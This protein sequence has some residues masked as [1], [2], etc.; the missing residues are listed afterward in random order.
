MP[1]RVS[2][3]AAA[4]ASTGLT[5]LTL[6]QASVMIR[7]GKVTPSELTEAC[8]ARIEIYNPKLDAF[9][10]VLRTQAME[11]ARILDQEQKSGKLRGPL[12]GIPVAV[13]DNMQT[14]GVRT[15]FGS[16]VLDS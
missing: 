9:I 15:T 2:A 16:A 10:T 4:P 13:K 11:Q 7:D 6:A 8:L 14:A 3:A 5:G 1:A 12:H